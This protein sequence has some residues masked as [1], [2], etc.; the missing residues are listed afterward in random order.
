MN[1]NPFYF[2]TEAHL[3]KLL[4]KKASNI[5]ELCDGIKNAPL[6]CIYYHTHRF[7][8]QHHYL[9]PEPPNDFAYWITKVLNLKT[10]GELIASVDTVNFKSIEELKNKFVEILETYLS[11]ENKNIVDCYKGQEFYFMSCKTFIL[12]TPYIANNL[13]EF[14]E[15]V[16]KIS[17]QSIY[18]H[19]FEAPKRL[20]KDENDF[21]AW[22]RSIGQESLA[23]K[24]SKL[25]PYNITLEELRKKIIN[26]VSENL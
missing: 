22:F 14:V 19:I 1:N 24:I 12:P 9:S 8:Q 15:I 16:K 25:D 7:L 23:E 13:S 21:Q 6:S 3:V 11:S 18:F 2:Y 10:L 17:I 5:I 4:G 20:K 26:F